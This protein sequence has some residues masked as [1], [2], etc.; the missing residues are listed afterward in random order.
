[1]P[2]ENVAPPSANASIE[3]NESHNLS[4][5]VIA[6]KEDIDTYGQKLFET[7]ESVHEQEKL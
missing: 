3:L 6:D 7:Q 1:V 5:Q 4:Y 2:Y